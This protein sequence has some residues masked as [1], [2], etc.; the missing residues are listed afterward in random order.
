M[1]LACW[2]E[3]I[4]V[5]QKPVARGYKKKGHD[6]TLYIDYKGEN[7]IQGS[8]SYKQNSEELE[9]AIKNAYIYAY[10]R[11]ILRR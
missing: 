6:V 11:L 5:G 9:N 1:M 7:K 3:K 8:K 10:N 2:Y 4:Y